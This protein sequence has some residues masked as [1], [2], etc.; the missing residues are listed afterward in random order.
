MPSVNRRDFVKQSAAGVA[1]AA[2]AY[3]PS[4]V[5]ADTPTINVGLLGCGR[6]R[7][8]ASAM[9]RVQG[10]KIAAVCD[11]DSNRGKP[12]ADKFKARYVGSDMREIF[13]DDKIQAVIVAT[14]DHW[15]GPAAIRAMEAGKHVYVEKPCSHNIREGQIMLQTAK[16]FNR[17]LQVGTQARS[18]VATREAIQRIHDG[19]IGEVLQAKC[20]NSQRRRN[21]GY[22]KQTEVPGHLD[23]DQWCGPTPKF[24]YRSN[25]VH[26]NW[27]WFYNFGTGDIGNDG[28]HEL[29]IARWGL[30]VDSHPHRVI[31][32]GGKLYFKDDQEFPDTQYV[33]YEFNQEKQ[34][35]QLVFE[36]RIW[37]PYDEHG[38]ANGNAFY[39]TKGYMILGKETGWQQFGERNK[40]VKSGSCKNDTNAHTANFITSIRTNATTNASI[41]IGHAGATLAH[42]GNIAVRVGES[43]EFDA[44]TEQITNNKEA[45]ALVGREYQSGHWAAI[46]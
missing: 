2:L 16:K 24:S 38:H 39:G 33:A 37:A 10:V 28:S 40:L 25:L 12:T 13:N 21:I 8:V 19:E 18:T 1:A 22:G 11:P 30:G 29:D 45:N 31:A 43:L 20:W 35:K 7:S 26:Y 6:G 15:H 42:L 32:A 9:L 4:S 27:H 23:F 36:Q 3:H 34:P 41:A 44:S 14:P 17:V 46:A 5:F